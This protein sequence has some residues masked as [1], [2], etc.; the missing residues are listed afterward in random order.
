MLNKVI[1]IGNIGKDPEIRSMSNGNKIA[2]FSVATSESWK[3]KNGERQ[4]KSEWHNVVIFSEGLVKVCQSYLNKG[5]KVYIEGKVQT[6]KWQDKSGQERYSTE[7]VLQ[8]FDAKLIMLDGQKPSSTQKA[9]P[10]P[11]ASTSPYAADLDDAIPFSPY[12]GV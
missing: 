3:D 4:T 11:Q 5:S 9:N 12:I 7:I 8:G 10:K 2:S 1:L 6:R